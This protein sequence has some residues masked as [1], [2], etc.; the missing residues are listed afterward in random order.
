MFAILRNE[1]YNQFIQREIR[2]FTSKWK[3]ENELIVTL[4]PGTI[5]QQVV[6]A[7]RSQF[8]T[9]FDHV[10]LGWFL[11]NVRERHGFTVRDVHQ[12]TGL[13]TGH[14]SR[15]ETGAG[16]G[17]PSPRILKKFADFYGVGMDSLFLF[18]GVNPP[19]EDPTIASDAFNFDAAFTSLVLHPSLKPDGLEP[20]DL[21]WIS[22]A[23]RRHWMEFARKLEKAVAEGTV[24]VEALLGSQ[25][26]G[27]G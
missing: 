12:G 11:R 26:G 9:V 15:I 27:E 14:I 21:Q 2:M 22:S 6:I 17:P 3:N 13:S 25:G 7:D 1:D 23:T 20:I 18:T 24:D 8:S 4:E 19:G 10:K 5:A 16:K